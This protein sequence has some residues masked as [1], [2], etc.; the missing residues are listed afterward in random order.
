MGHD[1]CILREELFTA[2]YRFL[3]GQPGDETP[4]DTTSSS[5]SGSLPAAQDPNY[6]SSGDSPSVLGIS[7]SVCFLLLFRFGFRCL[8]FRWI[9]LTMGHWISQAAKGPCQSLRAVTMLGLVLASA[10]ILLTVF[11]YCCFV[12]FFLFLT[13]VSVVGEATCDGRQAPASSPVRV[14]GDESTIL[15]PQNSGRASRPTEETPMTLNEL[16]VYL[17]RPLSADDRHAL[18]H[19]GRYWA[20][21]ALWASTGG[22]PVRAP[23]NLERILAL[24]PYAL[25]SFNIEVCEEARRWATGVAGANPFS[26]QLIGATYQDQ[27]VVLV[28]IWVPCVPQ[29]V[30]CILWACSLTELM[31]KDEFRAGFGNERRTISDFLNQLVPLLQLP[32]QNVVSVTCQILPG[33]FSFYEASVMAGSL[34]LLVI[35]PPTLC[36]REFHSWIPKFAGLPV[37]WLEAL[38]L[39]CRRDSQLDAALSGCGLNCFRFPGRSS[40]L[41]LECLQQNL[42]VILRR[43]EE[44]RQVLVAGAGTV[45][46]GVFNG[47]YAK[48]LELAAELVTGLFTAQARFLLFL[49][50]GT[51]I[52]MRRV[53][54]A[55]DPIGVIVA[56]ADTVNHLLSVVT[57]YGDV[58]HIPYM[59]DLLLAR[60]GEVNFTLGTHEIEELRHLD[61]SELVNSAG[62]PFSPGE[63][64]EVA[65]RFLAELLT[66]WL[67]HWRY[68]YESPLAR[69]LMLPMLSLGGVHHRRKEIG[70]WTQQ[71]YGGNAVALERELDGLIAREDPLEILFN[72]WFDGRLNGC[73]AL[74]HALGR[75]LVAN[76]YVV[77][78][79]FVSP[80][81]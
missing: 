70:E 55:K 61:L 15:L 38:R 44:I 40:W 36:G 33:R 78:P 66:R 21:D 42:D 18:L 2:M 5:G 41:F 47:S 57:D 74:G 10:S 19:A 27:P 39:E 77:C 30:R 11:R 3:D 45:D 29:P 60:N 1:W 12:F 48:R 59:W 9:L 76:K 50:N 67:R 68:L 13:V 24:Q 23:A 62:R 49:I 25:E 79:I 35:I 37:Q 81:F 8:M 34:E 80:F 7:V 63:I 16:R 58:Q 22:F 43:T 14:G 20:S 17:D 73:L 64:N 31:S 51:A 71:C 72:L 32:I 46:G 54:E 53:V 56:V 52:G 69:A 65:R 75:L 6:Q 4:M 26:L 28:A